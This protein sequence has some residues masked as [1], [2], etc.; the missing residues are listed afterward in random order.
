[1]LFLSCLFHYSSASQTLHVASMWGWLVNNVMERNRD[2]VRVEIL[3]KTTKNS[4]KLAFRPRFEP[5]AFRMQ[6]KSVTII[7]FRSMCGDSNRDLT[8]Y[9]HC[10][11]FLGVLKCN[12]EMLK[13]FDRS[14]VLIRGSEYWAWTDRHRSRT[15]NFLEHWP[16][17]VRRSDYACG[18]WDKWACTRFLGRWRVATTESESIRTLHSHMTRYS[19][20]SIFSVCTN[21]SPSA[22]C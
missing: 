12:A 6:V 11:L 2:T 3:G 15:D 22:P 19:K 21:S 10:C 4:G 16:V 14:A 13:R 8:L 17:T 9:C 7:S 18:E 1:M 20:C 5:D